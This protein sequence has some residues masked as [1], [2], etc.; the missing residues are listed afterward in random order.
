MLAHLQG[1]HD[2]RIVTQ[3]L[4]ALPAIDLT[5]RVAALRYLAGVA[6]GRP[7]IAAALD[8]LYTDAQSPLRGDHLLAS[9][10]QFVRGTP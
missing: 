5:D 9:V 7:R 6:G 8:E 3:L 1:I 4:A 10:L 2:E